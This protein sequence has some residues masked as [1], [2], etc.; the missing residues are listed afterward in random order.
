RALLVRKQME[1]ADHSLGG[2]ESVTQ[3]E[4]HLD[5]LNGEDLGM[6]LTELM[7]M[8]EVLDVLWLPGVGKKNRPA[9]LL[10]V[11]CQPRH[12]ETVA[13]AVIRHTHT[14]GLRFQIL[15]RMVIPRTPARLRLQGEALAAKRYVVEGEE[16]VRPEADE[17]AEAAR[18]LGVGVPAL[19][20]GL[21][22]D[23]QS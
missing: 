4:T 3:L 23:E 5:H 7:G 1:V 18:R 10:R 21:K 15:E 6:A 19:R 14:L 13:K 16:Y 12:R 8:P 11:L 17:L 2:R 20:Y 9:G 22:Y